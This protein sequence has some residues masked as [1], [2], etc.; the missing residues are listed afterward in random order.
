MRSTRRTPPPKAVAAVAAGAMVLALSAA[1]PAH[2]AG[3][4]TS[5]TPATTATAKQLS[6]GQASSLAVSSG[7]PVLATAMT[8]PT[9]E[10]TANPNGSFTM[11]ISPSPVRTERNG[12]WVALD[13]TL[14]RNPDG[15][16]SPAAIPGSLTLSA[17]GTGALATMTSNGQQMSLTL[18]A[19]LPKPTLSGDTATY[20]NVL[21]GT[22]LQV[23]ADT[24]G[25]F[26]DVFVVHNQAAA[27]N[28]QLQ[29]LLAAKITA[30][31]DLKLA[32][33]VTGAFSATLPDGHAAFVAPV[34]AAWDSNTTAPAASPAQSAASGAAAAHSTPAP[35]TGAQVGKLIP[36]SDATALTS[37]MSSPGRF[38]HQASL[39]PHLSHAVLSL[40]LPATFKSAAPSAFPE[41]LD[42]DFGPG[43]ANFASVSSAYPS[44]AYYN[45][46][47]TSGYMQVGYNGAE[48][49]CDPCFNARSFVTLSLTGLPT[50]A[51]D[52]SA[53]VQFW[54]SWTASCTAEELDLWQTG[55]IS[56]GTTWNNQPSW[57]TELGSQTVAKGW[58][59]CSAGGISYD[60][61]SAVQ[62]AVGHSSTITLGLRIPADQESSNDL[63]WRQLNGNNSNQSRTTAS[64]TYD[65]PPSTPSGLHTSPYTNCSN[66][67]LG[68]TGVTLYAPVSSPVGANLTTTFDFYN[69]ANGTN[70]LTSANGFASDTYSGASGQAAVMSLPE[71]FIKNQSGSSVAT[72]AW[73]A[74]TSDGTLPSGWSTPCTFKVDN[75]KPG[76][77]TVTTAATPPAG[78][79][80]CPLVPAAATQPIGTSCAFTF[81]IPNNTNGISGYTYQV[82]DAAPIEVNATGTVTVTFNLPGIVNTLTVSALSNGG[83]IGSATTEWFDGTSF[84]PAE[85]DGDLTGDHSPDLIVPGGTS[86]AFPPGLWLASGQHNGTVDSYAQNIGTGGLGF[87]ST[88]TATDWNGAQVITGDFCGQGTQ[89]VM[90]YYPGAQDGTINPDGG[91][92]AIACSTG[93]T[94]P[95]KVPVSGG[96]FDVQSNTFQDA[97]SAANA[98]QIAN[99]GQYYSDFAAADDYIMYGVVP[100]GSGNGVLDYFYGGGSDAYQQASYIASPNTPDGT[101][102][103]PSWQITTAQDERGGQTYT[104]MYLWNPT[105]GAL[106]L[107]AGLAP[108]DTAFDSG[109]ALTYTQYQIAASGWNT[110]NTNLILRAA[111]I[112]GTGNPGLWATN[113]ATGVTTSYIP[114]ANL[115]ASPVL[116]S[117]ST[118]ITTATHS[119]QLSDMPS[120][121][122]SGTTITTSADGD[123]TM[124][125]AA[126]SGSSTNGSL[127][128]TWDTGDLYSPD[129]HFDGTSKQALETSSAAINLTQSFTVSLWTKPEADGTMTLSESGSGYPGLMLYPDGT[130]GWEFYLAKDNGTTAWGGDAITGGN[131]DFGV[132]SHLQATY[133]ATTKVMELYVDN[134]LVATGSHTAPSAGATGPLVLGADIDGGNL[135]SFYSGQLANVQTWSNTALAPNQQPSAPSYH[136]SIEP[137]R[138]LDTRQSGPN[139]YSHYV[140]NDTPLGADTTLTLP[141]TGDTVTPATS[142]APTTIPATATAVAAD[143]TVLGGT[144]NGYVTIYADGTQQPITSATNYGINSTV[145]GY[146]IVP[147]GQD[148]KIDLYNASTGTAH[149]LV[150]IT[151]YFT[152]D[153]SLT[154]DQTY[155]PLAT[156]QRIFNTY[157]SDA[158]TSLTKTGPVAASTAFTVGIQNVDGI[159]ANA[160]AVAINLTT[161][162][163]TGGGFLEVY[164]TGTV[165]A[166]DTAL[167]YSS[168]IGD[169]SLSADA[170]VGT[171]GT[172]TIDNLG[173]AANVLGDVSGYY[174]ND[175]T[176]QA[177]HTV[178]PT[179]LLDTRSG[180]GTGTAGAGAI[181][182]NSTYPIAA[183]DTDQITTATSPTFAL[184][185]TIAGSTTIGDAIAYATGA[186]EPQT[187]N[188]NWNTNQIIANLALTPTSS[189]GSFT[190]A[191]QSNGATQLVIDTS[192]YFTSAANSAAPA[193][194]HQWPLNDGNGSS[195]RDTMG[196]IAN[197]M[198]LTLDGTYTWPTAT[199]GSQTNTPVLGL[200]G[201]SAY[202][203]TT[204]PVL[205]TA[206]SFTVSAWASLTTIPTANATIAAQ[207]GTE[208]AGFYLQYSSYSKAWC[209]GFM[210]SDVLNAAG[211]AAAPCT[212]TTPST[213]TWYQLTGVYN[214]TT[215]TAQLYVNGQ[216]AGTTTGITNWNATGPFTIG[217]AQYNAN[218]SDRFPGQI[219]NVQTYDSALASNQIAEIYQQQN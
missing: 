27:N 129:A 174:T 167:T 117:T 70:L 61:T 142:G 208:A 48:E 64:V 118:T 206:D 92:G 168:A 40:S 62:G 216:L 111:D 41:Y 91:G 82:N 14:H 17:G 74:M 3:A 67:T 125:L 175:T 151:G 173:S 87:N 26:S 85:T 93:T 179:R 72:F 63:N 68:D 196:G 77:P 30:S 172:I 161:T 53:D 182:A 44:Q 200:D 16:I 109:N 21:P 176:G 49:G 79:V 143:I 159:P 114:P 149:V 51:T 19:R 59:G 39:S 164:A 11:T 207:S 102:D 13:A 217:T 146:Q 212:S 139:T 214:A 203:T 69:T 133:N 152:S 219:S 8:T 66:T 178:N 104:D 202:A 145:T 71:S 25:G 199:V 75:S 198:P 83:N 15:T 132:W 166:A 190:I 201:S 147:L 120:S 46:A 60:I 81:K 108:N 124:P 56:S 205:N 123:G 171:G 185:L 96:Q 119:W 148:G 6:S 187:S 43:I 189:T 89:D 5:P 38:A 42:P 36:T 183:T 186:T 18:P 10:V 112:A 170:P 141:I 20:S 188:I 99:G 32:T 136:Q 165:P 177:Y 54:S 150:D 153:I 144:S 50:N 140:E 35:S 138:I 12:A 110:G 28:A 195:A 122:S 34:P 95:L 137:E 204:G 73:K 154:G 31:K 116:T 55:A 134:T 23:T 115:T 128:A 47:G 101:E 162:N 103:W 97:D 80:D 98:T 45:G 2:A 158:N 52:I 180:I 121:A 76:A 184:Q 209:L 163:E 160:T 135:T 157:S 113:T 197:A 126:P 24:Q 130:S 211:T 100:T 191:N 194:T 86:G 213:N 181:A 29:T 57:N 4:P 107:W 22:D 7:K 94:Q 127:A 84:N 9:R 1:T 58:T 90:A 155:H 33:D 65:V 156:A 105:T 88:A 192:G 78:S 218:L 131:V 37:S 215:N 106:Y 169:A 193:A 210:T